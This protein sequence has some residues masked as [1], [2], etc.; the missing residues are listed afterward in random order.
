M[1][2]FTLERDPFQS[3]QSA[4][5]ASCVIEIA[6]TNTMTDDPTLLIRL[7]FGLLFL[8]TLLAGVY[9]LRNYERLFGVDPDMPSETDSSRTYSKLQVFLVW[10][11]AVVLTGSFALLLH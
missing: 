4:W 5:H 9:L 3:V 8:G 1:L 10:A 6:I 11:H 7:P 2:L